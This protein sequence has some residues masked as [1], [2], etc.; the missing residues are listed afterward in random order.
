MTPTPIR[1][2]ADALEGDVITPGD[3]DYDEARTLFNGDDR[4]ATGRD[5]AVRDAST[6]SSAA[7]EVARADRTRRWRSAPGGHSVAGTSMC[8]DGLVIDVGG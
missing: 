4:P 8:D 3:A 6:T 2:L 1:A 5:R 7:L